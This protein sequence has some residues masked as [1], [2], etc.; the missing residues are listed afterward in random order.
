M[1]CSIYRI[2]N[3][4]GKTGNKLSEETKAKQSAAKKK[5]WQSKEKSG[6]EQNS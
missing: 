1:T 6:K 3:K 2:T 5:W 4:K